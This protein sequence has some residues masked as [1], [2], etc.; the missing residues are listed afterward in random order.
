MDPLDERKSLKEFPLPVEELE[1]DDSILPTRI[2]RIDTEIEEVNATIKMWMETLA[3]LKSSRVLLLDHAITTNH[4]EDAQFH[5]ERQ[6]TK[7]TGNRI[8]DPKKLKALPQWKLYADAYREKALRDTKAVIQKSEESVEK[9]ILIGLADKIFG[10]EQVNAC[11]TVPVQ[12]TV[13]YV[14]VKK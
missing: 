2:A 7:I 5:I 11:S 3:D 13:E 4:T 9:N 10:K 14:V 1:G 6:V 8:A 12:E